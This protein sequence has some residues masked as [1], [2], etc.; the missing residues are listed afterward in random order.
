MATS[1]FALSVWRRE[2]SRGF[3]RPQVAV[4]CGALFGSIFTFQ[5][6]ANY[7]REFTLAWPR[8]NMVNRYRDLYGEKYLLD[9]LDPNFR[10]PETTVEK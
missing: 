10:L 5:F 6:V 8:R 1:G 2:G 4:T 7:F 3:V 9:V